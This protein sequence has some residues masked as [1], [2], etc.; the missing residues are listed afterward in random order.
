MERKR[1]CLTDSTF[2]A[3]PSNLNTFSCVCPGLDHSNDQCNTQECPYFG[4]WS[5]WGEC[6]YCSAPYNLFQKQS[7]ERTLRRRRQ[8]S[9]NTRVSRRRYCVSGEQRRSGVSVRRIEQRRTVVWRAVVRRLGR[10]ELL[11]R[12]L[13]Y[14]RKRTECPRKKV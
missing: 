13:R 4:K 8:K 5:S 2:C 9:A 6:R 11:W 14:L 12:L 3:N 7:F 10:M 1:T